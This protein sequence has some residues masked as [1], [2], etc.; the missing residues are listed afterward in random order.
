MQGGNNLTLALTF[1]SFKETKN[2][3][4]YSNPAAKQ[5]MKMPEKLI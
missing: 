1:T 3:I 2:T 4:T 5:D